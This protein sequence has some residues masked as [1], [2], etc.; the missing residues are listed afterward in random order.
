V[1]DV[2]RCR[3][4]P[5]YYIRRVM[6]SWRVGLVL[7]ILGIVTA[8]LGDYPVLALLILA[9]GT[10]DVVWTYTDDYEVVYAGGES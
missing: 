4:R 1:S 7:M 2:I 10:V 8:L 9:A 6:E 5:Y 3:T